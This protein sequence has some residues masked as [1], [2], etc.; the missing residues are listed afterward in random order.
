VD[1]DEIQRRL[2]EFTPPPLPK[3]GWRRLY[4]ETVLPASQGADLS[5]L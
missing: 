4:A 5:F 3:R 1:A 2:E